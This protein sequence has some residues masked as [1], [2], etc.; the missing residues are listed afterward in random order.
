MQA[1]DREIAYA[2][3]LR[4]LRQ[5]VIFSCLSEQRDM[6]CFVSLSLIQ[7]EASRR[8]KDELQEQLRQQVSHL[9]L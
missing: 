9:L 4:Q 1:K 7:G 2:Q 6:Y 8:E 3:E 5:Q